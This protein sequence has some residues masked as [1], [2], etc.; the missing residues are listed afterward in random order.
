MFH[1]KDINGRI[2]ATYDDNGNYI[3]TEAEYLRELFADDHE[4]F[5]KY[6]TTVHGVAWRFYKLMMSRITVSHE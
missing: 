5:F 1:I 3:D 4:A 2:L 6:Q